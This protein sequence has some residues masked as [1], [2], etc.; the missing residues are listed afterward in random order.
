MVLELLKRKKARSRDEGRL[1]VALFSTD[2]ELRASLE[3]ALGEHDVELKHV[4][5]PAK[6]VRAARGGLMDVVV[7][8][9]Q[10][11]D[12][13]WRHLAHLDAG[14][15]ALLVG[16]ASPPEDLAT[17]AEILVLP[18]TRGASRGQAAA[19]SILENCLPARKLSQ[20]Q[21]R[22]DEL[23]R[24]LSDALAL[25]EN[26]KEHCEFYEMQRGR[27]A[28]TIKKTSFL[29]QLSK[30][31]NCLDVDKIV[32]L[33]TTKM[34]LIV[35]ASLCSIYFVEKDNR[36]LVLKGANHA[37]PIAERVSLDEEPPS[38]MAMAVKRKATLLVRDLDTLQRGLNVSI[39]R[40]YSKQ[41]QT[42]SCIVVPLVGGDEVLAVLN[43]ADK[44]NGG[45]FDEVQDLPLVDHI[46]QFI[47]IALKNCELYEEVSLQA[48]TDGL[49][50]FINHNAFFD[51]LSR[52]IE[53]SRRTGGYLS[54]VILDVDNFKLFNDVH[55]HQVGDMVL[56]E[57]AETIKSSIRT[58]DVPAR[59]GGDEFI[60]I[61]PD[62]ELERGH[63]VAE[64]I[65]RAIASNTVTL[66]GRSF[67]ITVSAGVAQF[68]PG[69]TGSQ[70]VNDVDS[71]LYEAKARGRNTVALA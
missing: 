68:Q 7:W 16:S 39:D 3:K 25:T 53:R 61:L 40:T 29:G 38:L 46:S 36:E 33:C 37:N 67:S 62:T 32:S 24:E 8:D 11:S 12:N 13:D 48:R 56:K 14:V 41:Y 49:T 31:I 65:R 50:D 51:E 2:Q 10:G 64:R 55:G 59:Y 30:E 44:A 63:L 60:I 43:L 5:S 70:M 17:D 35:D 9:T 71:A 28:E 18:T 47:G 4:K 52:E 45:R 1:A 69:Q 23:E 66:N 6:L 54:L 26:L 20:S 57:V 19:R 58:I 42:G 34:P 15:T 27:L 21:S 22:V